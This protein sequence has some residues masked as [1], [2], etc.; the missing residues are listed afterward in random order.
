MQLTGKT[1]LGTI[2]N[3]VSY[4]EGEWNGAGKHGDNDGF[5]YLYDSASIASVTTPTYTFTRSSSIV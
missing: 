2:A 5:M 3:T 4:G 1:A